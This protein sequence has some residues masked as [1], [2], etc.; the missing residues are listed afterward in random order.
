MQETF[1]GTQLETGNKPAERHSVDET[2]RLRAL[3]E[4]DRTAFLFVDETGVEDSLSY[5]QLDQKAKAISITLR[6]VACIGD[7]AML[8]LPPGFDFLGAFYGCLYSG[9]IAVPSP[10]PDPSRIARTLPRLRAIASDSRP[11]AALTTAALLSKVKTWSQ[12]APELKAITWIAID[13]LPDHVAEEE[14]QLKLQPDRIAFLQYTSGSTSSPKGVIVGL[15]NVTEN[16]ERIRDAWGY[17]PQSVSVI[18]VPNFH[19]DGLVHGT[20]QPVHSGF[21]CILMPAMSVVQ[22]P[23]KWLEVISRHKATHSGGP[24]FI[25]SLSVRKTSPRQREHLDLSSWQVAYNAAEPIHKETLLEFVDAFSPCGFKWET[26]FPAYGLA[27]ATLLVSTKKIGGAPAIREA[28]IAEKESHNRIIPLGGSRPSR[29]VVS[30]GHPVSGTQIVIAD[31]KELTPR[32]QGETGEIWIRNTSVAKGYWQQPESTDQ[33]FGAR[34]AND[35]QGPFLR[36]G[37]LGFIS[38][39]ELYVT[40]RLKDLI[41][42]AGRNHYPQDI[43]RT[44]EQSNKLLRP[45][46]SAAFS[47]EDS[48]G[49][50]LVIVAEIDGKLLQHRAADL[51]ENGSAPPNQA[52]EFE[53]V[54]RSVKRRVANNHDLNAS[55]IVLLKSGSI[56]KTSSGK[57]QR[58]ACKLGFLKGTLD[59]VH[60]YSAD[61]HRV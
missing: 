21:K 9:I 34:L 41:I 45:G 6:K 32:P 27:E 3:C 8:L 47:V 40:G 12:E 28:A 5:S 1:R 18:W 20:I 31:A 48:R 14:G 60:K 50:H 43:E 61:Q 56:P 39:G 17:N 29:C 59:M 24:N 23:F 30:C 35:G 58:H 26:F 7:R 42:I 44:T 11:K 25:Y 49:E 52:S 36:T 54:I 13:E 19:D 57:I 33:T 16:S 46:C 53:E 22:Q 4:P 2:L 55:V 15:D 38:D 10:P 37:D 51:N